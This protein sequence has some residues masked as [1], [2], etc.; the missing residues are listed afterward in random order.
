MKCRN[1]KTLSLGNEELTKILGR[2]C[3]ETKKLNGLFEGAIK[4]DWLNQEVGDV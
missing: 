1:E 3:E 4:D 2:L